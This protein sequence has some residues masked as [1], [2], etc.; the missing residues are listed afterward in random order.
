[1]I[2]F[3]MSDSI[4]SLAGPA[5][6]TIDGREYQLDSLS[7]EAR[8]QMARVT[9]TDRHLQQLQVEFV[10]AQTARASFAQQL[11]NLLPQ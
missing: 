5:T 11:K 8:E 10:I 1:L 3:G 4:E 7:A 2:F 6:V 9:A